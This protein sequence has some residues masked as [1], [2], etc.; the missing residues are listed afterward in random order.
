MH[1]NPT[2]P[3]KQATRTDSRVYPFGRF[4]RRH[5][6]DELPQ[7]LNVLTGDMSIVGPRPHLKEHT[8]GFSAQRSYRIRAFVKPGITGLAQ[9]NGC[10]G[11]VHS[12]ED[13]RRR[14]DWDIRYVESWSLL[15][16]L[17]I[18]LQTVREVL[19]PSSSAY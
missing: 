17:K 7:F 19:F 8:E 5:S 6:L 2:D 18:M 3:A 12:P 13:I 15:L 11:E 9:I 14:V 10:R 16:D 4:L 1:P